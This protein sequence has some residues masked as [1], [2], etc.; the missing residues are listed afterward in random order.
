MNGEQ[1]E[2]VRLADAKSSDQ[3]IRSIM[4]LNQH[5]R[6]G[7]IGVN[8]ALDMVSYRLYIYPLSKIRL[9][10][11][12]AELYLPDVAAVLAFDI[13]KDNKFVSNSV[14]INNLK[15]TC[16]ICAIDLIDLMLIGPDTWISLR[17][18]NR[19]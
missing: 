18:H 7:V 15:S 3:A 12:I 4:K 5:C 8:D 19:L 13:V 10:S 9:S 11:A 16:E 1:T 14:L 6:S 2:I 17:Q